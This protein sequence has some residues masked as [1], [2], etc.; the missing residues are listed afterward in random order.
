ML[1]LLDSE[2]GHMGLGTEVRM[3][4]LFA[5]PSA[6]LFGAAVDHFIGYGGMR[7]GG[8]ADLP[9]AIAKIMESPPDTVTMLGGSARHIWPSYAGRAALIV[10]G[11]M[12]TPDDRVRELTAT[13]EDAAR[14][15]ADAL[16][17]AIG[18]RGEHEG[19]YLR[20]LSDTVRRAALLEMPVVAHIYPRDYTDGTKIVFNPEEIAWAVRCGLETGVDV[21]KVGHPGD[22]RAFADIIRTCPVPVVMAGGPKTATFVEALTQIESG[23]RS[24]ARGAVVGRNLWDAPDVVGAAKACAAVIH[25]GLPAEEAAGLAA[26]GASG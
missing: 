5:H 15:G 16:A 6:N 14:L 8:L 21:I 23:M 26:P 19:A 10:Q 18:V 24:G 2:G 3:A 25:D 7:S 4:R 12:F 13:P 17:V 1:S 9:G 22:E 11:G 20:W